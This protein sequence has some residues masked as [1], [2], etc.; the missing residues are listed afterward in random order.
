MKKSKR[1]ELTLIYTSVK[2][3]PNELA[4]AKYYAIP[5]RRIYRIAPIDG[6]K[7]TGRSG[8]LFCIFEVG[9]DITYVHETGRLFGDP[10]LPIATVDDDLILYRVNDDWGLLCGDTLELAKSALIETLCEMEEEYEFENK[11]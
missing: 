7:L 8:A 10:T 9:G 11:G 1:F 5:N 3:L 2:T 6:E 4:P